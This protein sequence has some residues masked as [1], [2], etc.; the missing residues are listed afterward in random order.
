MV[1]EKDLKEYMDKIE[2]LRKRFMKVIVY[3]S[4]WDMK[5]I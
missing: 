1:E 3:Q 2:S 4:L 5:E